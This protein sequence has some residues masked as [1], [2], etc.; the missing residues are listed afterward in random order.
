[1]SKYFDPILY[2]EGLKRIRTPGITAG[3]VTAVLSSLS[4][5]Y[6]L[7]SKWDRLFQSP[8]S[9]G[10]YS[11]WVRLLDYEYLALP[12]YPL[13]LLA[14]LLTFCAF[15][16]LNRREDSDFYHALPASRTC[17]FLSHFGAVLT[18]LIGSAVASTLLA[19]VLWGI[20]P[21]IRLLLTD[22]LLV[23]GLNCCAILLVTALTALAMALTGTTL[24]NVLVTLLFAVSTRLTLC[25]FSWCIQEQFA[26]LSFHNTPLQ[27]LELP[28][29]PFIAPIR[30]LGQNNYTNGSLWLYYLLGGILLTALAC[31]AFCKRRS[32]MAGRSAPTP[33]IQHSFRFLTILPLVALT[34]WTALRGEGSTAVFFTLAILTLLIYY[35]YEIITTRQWKRWIGATVTLPILA[36]CG[37][38]VWGGSAGIACAA[39]SYVPDTDEI[40][41]VSIRYYDDDRL[42]PDEEYFESRDPAVCAFFANQ[43]QLMQDTVN[44]YGDDA[45]QKGYHSPQDGYPKETAVTITSTWGI[46]RTRYFYLGSQA[47]QELAELIRQSVSTGTDTSLPPITTTR[48]PVVTT[49]K[50]PKTAPDTDEDISAQELIKLPKFTQVNKQTLTHAGVTFTLSTKRWDTDTEVY[51]KFLSEYEH[52]PVRQRLE[53]RKKGLYLSTYLTVTASRTYYSLPLDPAL[54][55]NAC[56]ALEKEINAASEEAYQTLCEGLMTGK[57]KQVGMKILLNAQRVTLGAAGEKALKAVAYLDSLDPGVKWNCQL[58]QIDY[59]PEGGS[60]FT[61]IY[62]LEPEE[63]DQLWNILQ[64]LN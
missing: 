43:L 56:A 30:F 3:T 46:S 51:Q 38:A 40:R 33:V 37:L 6:H 23:L 11:Y 21:G 1:M 14:P 58:I 7:I 19:A 61:R 41:C 5:L 28:Y 59:T 4:P 62:F 48:P 25:F 9:Y 47:R 2:Q 18:W 44:A 13:I 45:Y 34:V 8:D 26:L 10:G 22:I 42:F 17:L 12:L 31:L 15:R 16:F 63:I 36:V 50:P 39:Q 53:Y 49:P 29:S 55:P 24:S 52:L 35:L 27:L 60:S 32:E 54:F 20:Q 64:L 57:T